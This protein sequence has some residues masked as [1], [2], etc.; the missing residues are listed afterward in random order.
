MSSS[1]AIRWRALF[2]VGC[3][4]ARSRVARDFGLGHNRR[5]LVGVEGEFTGVTGLDE[6]RLHVFLDSHLAP[7]YIAWVV[8]GLEFTQ[9]GLAVTQP[10]VPRLGPLVGPAIA[11]IQFRSG[12]EVI[13]HG[14]AG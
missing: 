7:G 6:D 5:F 13:V 3:D 12:A 1:T 10:H 4:G 2:L 8:P 14:A 9:V 11:I